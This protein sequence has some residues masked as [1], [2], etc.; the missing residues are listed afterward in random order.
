MSKDKLDVVQLMYSTLR[1]FN[2]M[3]LYIVEVNAKGFGRYSEHCKVFTF[4]LNEKPTPRDIIRKEKVMNSFHKY[5]TLESRWGVTPL[6]NRHW[7]RERDEMLR[8]LEVTI[9]HSIPLNSLAF[10]DV[11][12]DGYSALRQQ[13]NDYDTM[14]NTMSDE[15]EQYPFEDAEENPWESMKIIGERLS[16]KQEYYNY[17]YNRKRRRA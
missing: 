5:F 15:Y 3:T 1:K 16:D 2:D 17:L 14:L 12:L 9:L 6:D 7:E 11:E 10:D 4:M 13:H 8:N